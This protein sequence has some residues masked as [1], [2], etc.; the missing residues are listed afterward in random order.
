[1]ISWETFYRQSFAGRLDKYKFYKNPRSAQAP[2]E[3]RWSL[4][5]RLGNGTVM[6]SLDHSFCSS[7]SLSSFNMSGIIEWYKLCCSF[8]HLTCWTVGQLLQGVTN[9]S[10]SVL[11]DEEYRD[12]KFRRYLFLCCLGSRDW[13]HRTW[14]S[15]DD[16][17]FNGTKSF[18]AAKI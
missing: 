7:P 17:S 2:R 16:S 4:F 6:V 11:F 5:A 13:A 10:L 9:F 8:K 1:M 15:N 14:E 12:W 3:G 18:R